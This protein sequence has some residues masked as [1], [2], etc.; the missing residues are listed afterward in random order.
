MERVIVGM[1]RYIMYDK[2]LFCNISNGQEY[3]ILLPWSTVA[4]NQKEA[5]VRR[6]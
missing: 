5:N 6:L 3:K 2:W 1:S 4:S